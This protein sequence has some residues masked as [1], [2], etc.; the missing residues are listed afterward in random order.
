MARVQEAFLDGDIYA[1]DDV[2]CRGLSLAQ[3]SVASSAQIFCPAE[4]DCWDISS[5]AEAYGIAPMYPMGK[6]PSPADNGSVHPLTVYSQRRAEQL[7]ARFVEL[8]GLEG[9]CSVRLSEKA[10]VLKA[11]VQLF[12]D[13]DQAVISLTIRTMAVQGGSK[14]EWA[15]SR[16]DALVFHRIFR[17]VKAAERAESPPA[18]LDHLQG[19]PCLL[20][21]KTSLIDA[22]EG[23][24]VVPEE[25]VASLARYIKTL[26]DDEVESLP[27]FATFLVAWLESTDVMVVGPA[28]S[29]AE[30]LCAVDDGHAEAFLAVAVQQAEMIPADDK[31]VLRARRLLRLASQLARA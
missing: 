15:R 25:T 22:F 20:C 7:R 8:I 10:G 28:C 3:F 16:G 26:S 2:V 21:P 27:R 18:D 9:E 6:M 30:R 23:A 19:V 13:R 14:A 5:D 24:Q 4:V 12:A 29:I 1:D 17:K 11:R 31:H